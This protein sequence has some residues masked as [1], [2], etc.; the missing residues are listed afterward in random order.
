MGKKGELCESLHRVARDNVL[1][2]LGVVIGGEHTA[3]KNGG[4]EENKLGNV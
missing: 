1:G 2:V 3:H 4:H